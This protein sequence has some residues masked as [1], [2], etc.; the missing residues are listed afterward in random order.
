M[1]Q[2]VRDES[3]KR[4]VA[5]K[6]R[7]RR[8]RQTRVFHPAEGERWRQ[9]EKVVAAPAVWSEKRFGCGHHFF[10]VRKLVGGGSEHGRFG[11]DSRA[12]SQRPNRNI[13]NRKRD[14]I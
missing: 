14:Q 3:D 8:E 10:E 4:A 11:V 12:R 7:W 13:A 6:D 9:D 1:R 5:G 2:F